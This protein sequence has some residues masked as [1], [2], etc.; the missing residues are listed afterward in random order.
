MKNLLLLTL[1][2]ISVNTFAI[3]KCDNIKDEL[4]PLKVNYLVSQKILKHE[5][6]N[7]KSLLAEDKTFVGSF[8]VSDIEIQTARESVKHEK[9]M[10]RADK[11][12]LKSAAIR[13]SVCLII[14]NKVNMSHQEI[15][16][17]I[18]EYEVNA[19]LEEALRFNTKL[20]N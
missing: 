20:I 15:L 4:V 1:A 16:D 5:Y 2:M 3:D 13:Y 10:M 7:L 6:N 8:L 12:L 19:Q 14:E 9:V 17:Q 11:S 18:D